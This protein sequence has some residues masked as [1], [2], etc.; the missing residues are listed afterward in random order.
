MAEKGTRSGR[1]LVLVSGYYGFG[2]LGDEAILEEIVNELKKL[3]PAEDIVIL[4]NKPEH[5]KQIHGVEAIDRWN[6]GTL[7]SHLLKTRLFLSGGGGLFQDVNSAGSAVFYGLQIMLAKTLGARTICY[8]QG[9]GPLKTALG[10]LFARSALAACESVS[11]R[12]S[13]SLALL[14]S[15]GIKAQLT[16]DPVWA[17]D[18][19][20]HGPEIAQQLKAARKKGIKR[21]IGLSL[22]ESPHFSEKHLEML[23]ESL[24]ETFDNKTLLVLLPFQNELDVKPL[25]EAGSS[26]MAHERQS[27]L[28]DT[29]S[30]TLPSQWLSL[31]EQFDMVVAMRLHASIMALKAG[32]PVVG[33]AY[34]PKV[35]RVLTEFGQPILILA[36]ENE[37][38]DMQSIWTRTM[39]TA[40]ADVEGLRA[41]AKERSESAKKL[42]CQNFHLVAKILGMQS[43]PHSR[44]EPSSP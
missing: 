2:N 19:K 39:K 18:K 1:N 37:G 6:F 27:H 44:E 8:A 11:V 22:R 42:A 32:V 21:M 20:A 3:V 24:R 10:K 23:V 5:H 13:E 12:D 38:A 41:L 33:I 40:L 31:M 26:W 16:A 14:S 7:A 29:A 43:D 4:S 9:L 15:W 30:L 25:I 34:D 36:K 17:L 35:E 28:L